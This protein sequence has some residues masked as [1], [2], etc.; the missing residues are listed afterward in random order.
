MA[1]DSLSVLQG[2]VSQSSVAICSLIWSGE[3]AW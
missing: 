1:K 2:S 3:G